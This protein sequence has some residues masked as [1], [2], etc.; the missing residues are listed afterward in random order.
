MDIKDPTFDIKRY[1]NFEFYK[2]SI[3][4]YK[5][6]ERLIKKT[7]YVFHYAGIAS[8]DQYVFN[9]IKVMDLTALSAINIT[10]LCTK[11]NKILFFT[12]TSEIYGKNNQIPFSE[13]SNRVLGSTNIER[14]CYSSSKALVEHYIN[15]LHKHN[16]LKFVIFRLFNIYGPGIEGRVVDKFAINAIN[17]KNLLVYGNG[18][19]TRCFLYID[20]CLDAFYKILKNKKL[21]NKTYN[22][23]NNKKTNMKKLAQITK[24]LAKSK[25]NIKFVDTKVIHKD[26]F[27]DID[28]RI[29]NIDLL[30][31]SI[32]WKPKI[33]IEKGMLKLINSLKK[34]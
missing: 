25:S 12:S 3:F 16:N 34:R 2:K 17:N 19:Q 11:H 1:K 14:W 22:I 24:K 13:N 6:V 32:S 21:L 30:N 5:I 10:K 31:K 23:G 20:D 4:Q 9:P 26:G 7:D 28:I 18:K 33:N 27:E 15:A 8:P 29:P